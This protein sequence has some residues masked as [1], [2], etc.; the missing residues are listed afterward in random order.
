MRVTDM[1]TLQS[2]EKHSRG[3]GSKLMAKM[4]Y[5][6][7]GL[8]KNASGIVRAIEPQVRPRQMGIA[9][10]NF[11]ERS[12]A[13]DPQMDSKR[14]STPTNTPHFLDRVI[15]QAEQHVNTLQSHLTEPNIH[16]Q[17]ADDLEEKRKRQIEAK[18][19]FLSFLDGWNPI[20]TQLLGSPAQIDFDA[21]FQ[22]L[23][24]LHSTYPK[25]FVIASCD[26]LSLQVYFYLAME[27]IEDWHITRDTN[28]TLGLS[29]FQ[30]WSPLFSSRTHEIHAGLSKVWLHPLS[31]YILTEWDPR[32][33]N[34]Q[35]LDL[36]ETS[37]PIVPFSCW[38]I[39][40][41]HLVVPRLADMIHHWPVSH[42][43]SE[44]GL[45]LWVHPWLPLLEPYLQP[46]YARVIEKLHEVLT[47]W[48][49]SSSLAMDLIKPWEIVFSNEEWDL[50]IS[51][52]IAPKLR[53]MCMQLTPLSQPDL[54]LIQD[55]L[56]HLFQWEEHLEPVVFTDILIRT[57]LPHW[58]QIFKQGL[59]HF[60][61]DFMVDWYT[62]TKSYLTSVSTDDAV[63]GIFK[64]ALMM[65]E[66]ASNHPDT[67]STLTDMSIQ[68]YTTTTNLSLREAIVKCDEGRMTFKEA[69]TQW[70]T[71][72]DRLF[73]AT[74]QNHRGVTIY[75]LDDQ[76]RL[77]FPSRESC[78]SQRAG[79]RA[80]EDMDLEKVYALFT[81]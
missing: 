67:L 27:L 47:S 28:L 7:G 52:T 11:Q 56:K 45:H 44:R 72:F 54:A 2:M 16:L 65:M 64:Q 78:L 55:P 74:S 40:V 5:T 39:L 14:P 12:A 19:T 33:E 62:V 17:L 79:T 9:Y 4:G 38:E 80:W 53:I 32:D 70:S 81:A 25:E 57:Y 23:E 37:H 73:M 46:V 49:P 60:T 3:I 18:R 63:V 71:E 77:C 76:Y 42:I 29:L 66:I 20:S 1:E 43:T 69:V 36:C 61:N 21:L 51:R 8:G 35:V 15:T 30:T 34:N 41:K 13:T 48:D 10:N 58:L 50:L 31:S 6:G 68:S 75:N 22:Q 24:H 26:Q 59:A